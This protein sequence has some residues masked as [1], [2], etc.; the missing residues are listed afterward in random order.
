ME[1]NADTTLT[2]VVRGGELLGFGSANPRTEERFESGKYTT[3]YGLA[4]AVVRAG[5]TGTVTISIH[6]DGV[7]AG[8]AE[9]ICMESKED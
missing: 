8:N 6:G 2:T 3:Y 1:A 4:Q 9:I 7:K 5:E